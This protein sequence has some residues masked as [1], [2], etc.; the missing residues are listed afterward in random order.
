M[1]GANEKAAGVLDTLAT[2]QEITHLDS[3]AEHKK[4][5]TMAAQFALKGHCMRVNTRQDG[6]ISYVVSRWSQS[7]HFTDWADVQAFLTQVGGNDGR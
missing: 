7:R 1:H 2:A 3:T 6:T 4:A 5:A